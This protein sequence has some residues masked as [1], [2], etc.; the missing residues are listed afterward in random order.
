MASPRTKGPSAC[1]WTCS[2]GRWCVWALLNDSV[3]NRRANPPTNPATAVSPPSSRPSGKRST[4]AS[5]SSIP[6][7]KAAERDR[8]MAPNSPPSRARRLAAEKP[9]AASEAIRIALTT[10][11]HPP[12][13]PGSHSSLSHT[14]RA[15]PVD[16]EA[17]GPDLEASASQKTVLQVHGAPL[18]LSDAPTI[19]TD[20]VVVAILGQFVARTVTKVEP[21]DEPQPAEKVQRPVHRNHPDLGTAGPY[22]LQ[23]LMPAGR[24]HLQNSQPLRRR[25]VPVSPYLPDCRLETHPPPRT[26]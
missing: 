7:A 24:N 17:V 12:Q 15:R 2:S 13:R 8:P 25:F 10:A 14:R 16:L 26:S 21:A 9:T 5:A 20:E 3:K 6:A 1:L 19:L 23:T 18:E 11:R 4:N 22:L